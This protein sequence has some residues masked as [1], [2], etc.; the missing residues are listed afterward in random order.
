M[1]HERQAT[2]ATSSPSLAMEEDDDIIMI[3]PGARTVLPVG[4]GHPPSGSSTRPPLF[5]SA[6]HA[7]TSIRPSTKESLL[8]RPSPISTHESTPLPENL[9]SK[10]STS[11]LEEEGGNAKYNGDS[12]SIME[13]DSDWPDE[14]PIAGGLL[15]SSLATGLCYD[16]RMRYHCEVRPTADV[17]PEDPRR[18]YYIYKELCRAGLVDDSEAS[19]PLVSRPLQRIHVRNASEDEIRLVHTPDHYA[20]VESTKGELLKMW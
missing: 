7:P 10:E 18:I 14:E 15:V 13:E 3:D 12:D 8:S 1:D 5:E 6:L 11:S 17:H 4:S 9:I 16:T 19:K 2:L 20:F